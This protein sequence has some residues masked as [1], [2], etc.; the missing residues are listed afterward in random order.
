MMD[1]QDLHLIALYV[2]NDAITLK[3]NFTN[4]VATHLRNDAT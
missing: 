2:I 1:G 4:V 3:D